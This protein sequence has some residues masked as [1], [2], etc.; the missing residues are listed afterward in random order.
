[1][2]DRLPEPAGQGWEQG[3]DQGG[4]PAARRPDD[5]E[6]AALVGRGAGEQ[7]ARPVDQPFEHFELVGLH[8]TCFFNPSAR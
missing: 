7:V 5:A 6:Q 2:R 1:M 4:L 3:L 8:A